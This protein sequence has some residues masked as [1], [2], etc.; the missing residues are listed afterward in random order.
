MASIY[1][2]EGKTCNQPLEL[3]PC[4]NVDLGAKAAAPMYRYLLHNKQMPCYE[5]NSL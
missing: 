4:E 2:Q 3:N 5:P 1:N